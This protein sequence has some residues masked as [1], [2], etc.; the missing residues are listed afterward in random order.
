MA[1]FVWTRARLV[2]LNHP[3]DVEILAWILLVVR[4]SL[5]VW[6]YVEAVANLRSWHRVSHRAIAWRL[7]ETY[8]IVEAREITSSRVELRFLKVERFDLTYQ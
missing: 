7:L 5:I 6:I 4:G 2:L 8:C 3:D 1:A